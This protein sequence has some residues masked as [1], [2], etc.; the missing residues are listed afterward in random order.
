MTWLCSFP[1]GI[2]A[3]YLGNRGYLTKLQSRRLFTSLGFFGTGGCLVWLSFTGCH[4]DQVIAALCVA[5]A[6][7]AGNYAGFFV[8]KT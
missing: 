2:V 4:K 6:F 1:V 8:C 5:M 7:Y 3:D